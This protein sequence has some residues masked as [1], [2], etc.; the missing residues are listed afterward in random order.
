MARVYFISSDY[1]KENSPL[2]L[3]IDDKILQMV[4]E[5]TQDLRIQE[6]VGTSQYK[7]YQDMLVAYT[8]ATTG[9]NSY[10]ITLLNDYII[11][12]L[13]NY[14]IAEACISLGFK[15]NTKGVNQNYSENST[16]ANEVSLEYVRGHYR[17]NAEFYFQR[18]IDYL[19]SYQNNFP[20]YNSGSEIDLN[21]GVSYSCPIVLDRRHTGDK[22]ENYYH[23]DYDC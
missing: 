1:L 8:G 11:P 16:P 17:K 9:L 15:I 23:D 6:M 20:N 3:N 10:E 12:G 7:H 13:L 21:G 19:R 22:D 14:S 2:N 5:S 4:I 18:G